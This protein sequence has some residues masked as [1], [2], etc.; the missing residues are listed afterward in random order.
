[1][2]AKQI[3]KN[4]LPAVLLLITVQISAQNNKVFTGYRYHNSESG[5]PFKY[6]KEYFAKGKAYVTR[7]ELYFVAAD[8]E[9]KGLK[10]DQQLLVIHYPN[11]KEITGMAEFYDIKGDI[12]SE[13]DYR[14]TAYAVE[15]NPKDIEARKSLATIVRYADLTNKKMTERGT[16][17]MTGRVPNQMEVKFKDNNFTYVDMSMFLLENLGIGKDFDFYELDKF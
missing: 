7:Y 12:F 16:L 4:V 6:T 14:N 15:N 2:K 17:T 9:I 11:E 1:M 8:K 5:K 10:A 3:M 13:D